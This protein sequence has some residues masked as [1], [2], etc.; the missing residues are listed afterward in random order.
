MCDMLHR[1]EDIFLNELDL[2]A[3][4]IVEQAILKIDEGCTDE[5]WDL[6]NPLVAIKNRVAIYY[7]ACF[8]ISGESLEMFEKR[9]IRELWQS[10]ELGYAPAIHELAIHY[11]SGEFVIRD[12]EKAAKLFEKAAEKGHPHSQWIHGVDL[13]YGR[14]GFTRD[15]VLG[16]EYIKKSA[17]AKFEGALESLSNFYS[18]GLFGFPV[19]SGLAQFYKNQVNNKELLGY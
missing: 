15:E 5:A 9:R 7:S 17:N 2:E 4:S 19:D 11:D 6:L 18:K 8:S 12:S 16:I 1:S 13:L 10:A 3:S 14:S